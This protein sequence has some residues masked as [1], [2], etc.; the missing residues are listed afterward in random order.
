MDTPTQQ[1]HRLFFDAFLVPGLLSFALVITLSIL[2]RKL[3]NISGWW[4]CGLFV[5]GFFCITCLPHAWLMLFPE[6]CIIRFATPTNMCEFGPS[7]YL[8]IGIFAGTVGALMALM[9]LK[10]WQIAASKRE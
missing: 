6:P 4:L 5:I 10:I 9:S 2:H 1:L 3:K 7:V 8:Q